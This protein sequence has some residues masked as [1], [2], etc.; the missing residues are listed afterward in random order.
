MFAKRLVEKHYRAITIGTPPLEMT[1][2]APIGRNQKNR[3]KMAVREGGRR[4]VSHIKRLETNGELSLVEVAIETG[5]THQIRVHLAYLR[6]PILGDST[7]GSAGAN[8]AYGAKRQMLHAKTLGFV[9]PMT[10]QKL[11]LDAPLPDDFA[12]FTKKIS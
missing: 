3:Q 12:A 11:R 5:R 9:H 2:D 10:G 7:Y 1:I 4:A 6:T 8:S